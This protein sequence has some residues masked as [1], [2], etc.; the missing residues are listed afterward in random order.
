M[1]ASVA[2]SGAETRPLGTSGFGSFRLILHSIGQ[3]RLSML[4]NRKKPYGT[5]LFLEIV[6]IEVITNDFQGA[7]QPSFPPRLRLN[8]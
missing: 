5:G 8:T 1:C 4:T 6:D 7:E 2:A 3:I